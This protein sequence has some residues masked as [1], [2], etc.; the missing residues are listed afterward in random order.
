MDLKVWSNPWHA[1]DEKGRPCGAAQLKASTFDGRP[2]YIGATRSERIV[3]KRPKWDGRKD[4]VDVTFAFSKDAVTV[5]DD[6]TGYYRKMVKHGALF[7]A[8]EATAKA[9]GVPFLAYDAAVS[10]ARQ[11]AAEHSRLVHGVCHPA[12]A[13]ALPGAAPAPKP[14][15]AASDNPAAAPTTTTTT[16]KEGSK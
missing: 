1:V 11:H 5:A 3:E 4:L 7:A 14:T 12:L 9:C 10:R 13:D 15:T 2:T 8:D 16:S 6:Y